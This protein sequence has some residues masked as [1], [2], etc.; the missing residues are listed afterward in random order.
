MNARSS[1]PAARILA[2]DPGGERIG[3]AVSDPTGTIASP[4][5]VLTHRSRVADAQAILE[6]ARNHS[7][8]MIVIGQ[9]L[10]TEGN[11]TFEGR[12]ARR[13]A[14]ALRAAGSETVVLWDETG[15][16]QEARRAQI[17]M[18]IARKKRREPP[19]ALAAAVIL[20][21]FLDARR[22]ERGASSHP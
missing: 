14:G 2:V 22:R 15:T 11:P 7:A 9:A 10:D 20:Q 13:L 5:T 12:R 18:G 21:S 1:E 3:L 17:E 16:T 4:L 8:H 6:I 19:D